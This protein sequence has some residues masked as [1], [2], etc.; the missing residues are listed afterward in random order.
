MKS[1]PIYFMHHTATYLLSYLASSAFCILCNAFDTNT[2]DERGRL[3][4]SLPQLASLLVPCLQKMIALL[5][6]YTLRHYTPHLALPS[7]FDH[8]PTH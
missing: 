4:L 7:P 8:T 1:N 3:S 6:H 2:L 5:S